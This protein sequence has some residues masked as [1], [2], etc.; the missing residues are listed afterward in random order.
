MDEKY[1]NIPIIVTSQGGE[2]SVEKSFALGATDFV[3]KPYNLR[4]IF[5]RVQNAVMAFRNAKKIRDSIDKKK[6][7]I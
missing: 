1:R 3:E 7:L 6:V 4:I 5:H 2:K